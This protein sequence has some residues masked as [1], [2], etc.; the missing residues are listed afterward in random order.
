[1]KNFVRNGGNPTFTAPAGGVVSGSVYK[2]GVAIVVACATV[3]AGQPFAGKT[4]GEFTMPAA[5]G[6]AWTEGAL[7]Y[8]DD[9]A[10]NLTTTAA[11]N[12]KAGYATVAKLSAAATGTIELIRTI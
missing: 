5:T 7:V 11:S 8:W 10:K 2:I 6:Q 3:A 1:M 9:T 12:Q 4:L